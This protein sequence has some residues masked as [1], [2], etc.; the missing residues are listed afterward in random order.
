MGRPTWPSTRWHWTLNEGTRAAALGVDLALDT[1]IGYGM[2][3]TGWH[4]E[5]FGVFSDTVVRE[6]PP[7]LTV[8]LGPNEAGKSTL[9]AFLRGVLFGFPDSD[10]Q[11]PPLYGGRHG[12]RLFVR[13]EAGAPAVI[14]RYRGARAPRV[15]LADGSPGTEEDLARLVG[16]ADAELFR[17]VFAFSLTEL[18]S[19]RSLDTSAVR[20][21]I[22]AAGVAGAGRSARS[23]VAA[24][25][26]R[27][28]ALLR[29]R[30]PSAEIPRLAEALRAAEQRLAQ[31]TEEAEGYER[32]R[33]EEQHAGAELARLTDAIVERRATLRRTGMLLELWPDHAEATQAAAELTALGP[34]DAPEPG[35]EAR[36]ERLTVEEALA[37]TAVEERREE[38][39]ALDRRLEARAPDDRLP[40]V[41]GEAQALRAESSAHAGR[42]NR[43][44]AAERSVAELEARLAEELA[45]LGGEWDRGR[46]LAVDPSFPITEEI[47]VLEARLAR[48]AERSEAVGQRVAAAVK[49]AGALAE[50]Q[51]RLSG[52][53]RRYTAVPTPEALDE[54]DAA[55]RRLRATLM[56]HG[57]ASARAEA[58]ARALDDLR[59]SMPG[60]SVPFLGLP[61][62]L[63]P[64]IVVLAVALGAGAGAALA[65]GQRPVGAIAAIG[66]VA[67]LAVAFALRP[68]ALTAASPRAASGRAQRQERLRAQEVE[69]EERAVTADALQTEVR[70]L[71]GRLELPPNPTPLDVEE[72]AALADR[73]RASRAEAEHASAALVQAGTAA[74]EAEREVTALRQQAADLAEQRAQAERE[75]RDWKERHHVRESLGPQAALELMATVGRA[76]TLLRQL[77]P[78]QREAEQLQRATADYQRRVLAVLERAGGDAGTDP[79]RAVSLLAERVDRD[80][81]VRR[82][83]VLLGSERDATR[84]RL[85]AAEQRLAGVGSELAVVLEGVGGADV[86]GARERIAQ[87]GRRAV[88]EERAHAARERIGARTGAGPQA[89]ELTA[90]LAAGDPAE[91]RARR[92]EAEADLPRLEQQ[93]EDAVRRQHDA[94]NRVAAIERSDSVA[95]AALERE[96]LRTELADAVRTWQDLTLARALVGETLRGYE[97]ERQPSVLARASALFSEVTQ[98]RYEQ[99]VVVDS[100]LEVLDRTGARFD[101]AALSRGTAEQLYMCIR[102]GLAA[103]I[104]ANAAPLPL[105]MDDVLVNFDPERA[106]GMAQAIASLA[107][108]HQVLL[109]TSHPTVADQLTELRP[110]TRVL[111]LTVRGGGEGA[112]A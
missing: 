38:L 23:A 26:R 92:A 71:A 10:R 59:L 83:R 61:A 70:S 33:T 43:R 76:R 99:V 54:A 98:G 95:R 49:R 79:A 6:L 112:A 53:L 102:F 35:A 63:R 27:R 84:G 8:V 64:V 72:R 89:E 101:A 11:Y 45:R 51:R 105:V 19:L 55:I 94:A 82:E 100:G 3:I 22:F 44:A 110:G 7:E 34:A 74:R 108:E 60:T 107:A 2:K 80:D 15:F 30:S 104:A 91:W 31:A 20:D 85:L 109:F 36:L 106:R 57:L 40:Q 42:Q 21:R 48:S 58:S 86:A 68:G 32:A 56:D 65:A 97:R 90:A 77:E 75:W 66:A 62:W 4:I 78:L 50:E 96:G 24:L 13:D 16:H 88:L 14:E 52:E 1:G 12:G 41:A 87:A 29:P 103:E 17:T 67:L 25:D 5:G 69:A 46:I 9:L 81:A 47:R 37:R 28:D 18:E 93:R 73:Q 39:A 111:E